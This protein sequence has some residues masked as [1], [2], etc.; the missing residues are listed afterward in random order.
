MEG[1]SVLMVA[2]DHK[3]SQEVYVNVEFNPGNKDMPQ[4]NA[5]DIKAV[6]DLC[7]DGTDPE[8]TFIDMF[9]TIHNGVVDEWEV[10]DDV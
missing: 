3:T 6:V 8:I 2:V 7:N 9:G 5:R 10:I 4:N 1:C